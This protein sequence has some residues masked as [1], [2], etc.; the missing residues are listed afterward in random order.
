MAADALHTGGVTCR[1]GEEHALFRRYRR[2]RELAVRDALIARFMP[3]ARSLARRYPAGRGEHED[4]MQVAALALMK[5]VERFDPDHG[6]AFTS[7]AT[8]TIL[9][10][11]KRYFRDYGWTIRVPRELQELVGRI[12]RT[13]PRLSAQLGREPTP[14]ELAAELDVSAEHVLEARAARAAHYPEPLDSAPHDEDEPYRD[15]PA[16]NETGYAHAEDAAAVDALLAQL[17]GRDRNIVTLRFRHE[18]LQREI[19]DLFGISQMQVSRILSRSLATL[20]Q[21]A[22]A[23]GA[24]GCRDWQRKR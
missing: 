11:I 14:G 23:P 10:E 19:A 2:D 22:D 17:P 20:Q 12:E 21:L 8:P 9:G 7:F 4:V 5:A 6:T 24:S 15:A 1:R 16:V 13:T 18:L 3:L